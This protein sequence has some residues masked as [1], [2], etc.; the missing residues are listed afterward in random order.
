MD[1]GFAV[2]GLSLAAGMLSTLSPCVLPLAPILVGTA[3]SAHRLGPLALAGGVAASFAAVG[4]VVAGLGAAAGF[5]PAV[6][7]RVAAAVLVGFAVVLLAPRL[8]ERFAVATSA[9][10]GAGQTALSRLTLDGL[11]GQFVLGLL[12]GVAW[13]PCVGPTLGAAVTLASQGKALSQVAVVMLVFGVG[14]GLP[15][16]AVGLVSRQA[17][18]G[19]R[20][21]LL[22]AGVFGK[23]VF[24]VALLTVGLAILAGVDKAVEGWLLEASPDWLLQLTTS[25]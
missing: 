4:T 2:F 22:A 3:L 19:L 10:S 20:G 13:S 14:A 17:L 7:R 25:L 6:F 12:L 15:L 5:D 24:G 16:L 1:F 9:L 11:T 8:Q 21:R 18:A 23:R